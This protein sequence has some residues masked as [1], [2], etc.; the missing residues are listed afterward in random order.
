MADP[1][2]D[3]SNGTTWAG[4]G[5][6]SWTHTPAGTNRIMFFAICTN[7]AGSVA[8]CTFASVA[9]TL[10]Y[11]GT[12]TIN[13]VR[14]HM[15]IWALIAPTAAIGTIAVTSSGS[16]GSDRWWAVSVTYTEAS[17]TSSA[18]LRS[19]QELATDAKSSSA[20]VN[21]SHAPT[22]EDTSLVI[23]AFGTNASTSHGGLA[24]GQTE[25]IEYVTG[26]KIVSW[27][28]K[29]G[30]AAAITVSGSDG[31][32]A[33]G[34]AALAWTH[35][36]LGP[37]NVTVDLSGQPVVAAASVVVGTIN[38]SNITISGLDAVFA[39]L[40]VSLSVNIKYPIEADMTIG[41]G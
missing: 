28:D 31:F 5:T 1:A 25:R 35:V 32:D 2:Y 26:S 23:T 12:S 16:S 14:V 17:Q 29:A 21:Y 7:S 41:V 3:S 11:S 39:A 27:G 30:S 38:D 36:L 19:G 33:G 10:V 22:A 9:A 24:A 4:T 20:N 13:S 15:E 34:T 8:A 6:G 37:Q 40:S 18:Y